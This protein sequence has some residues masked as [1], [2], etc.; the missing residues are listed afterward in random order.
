MA[1]A[2]NAKKKVAKK[3]DTIEITQ[4]EF[5]SAVS[6]AV[7][8]ALTKE[9]L[10][11][12]AP[13]P[14]PADISDNVQLKT[15]LSSMNKSQLIQFASDKFSLKVEPKL[16]E[17]VIIENL[18]KLDKASK[19]EAATMN[20]ESLEKTISEDDPPIKVRFFNLQSPEEV[21]NFAFPGPKG[22][23]GPVNKNGHKKSPRYTLYPGEEYILALSVKDHLESLTFTHY[24]T[25][26]DP[27]TGQVAGNEPVL[28]PK[29]ILNPVITKAQLLELAK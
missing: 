17:K 18:L 19:S 1:K 3:A 13:K 20:E 28:K 29:Y 14:L 5:E 2:K 21:I 27:L 8:A 15:R 10:D 12:V 25:K 22:M 24:K 23:K 9:R 16:S 11:K 26:I 4:E 7:Q 6:S